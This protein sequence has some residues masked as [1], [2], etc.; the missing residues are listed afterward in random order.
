VNK[1]NFDCFLCFHLSC[2]DFYE[3]ACGTFL[4]NTNTPDEKLSINTESVLIDELDGNLF[5][6]LSSTIR[7]D[8]PLPHKTAKNVYRTC[9]DDGKATRLFWAWI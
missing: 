3:F 4:A 6:I 1:K 9:M 2:E 7:N 5:R 8:E